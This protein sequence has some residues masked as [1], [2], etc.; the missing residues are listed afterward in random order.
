VSECIEG[1]KIFT[2]HPSINKSRRRR[3]EK[4][5]GRTGWKGDSNEVF[6]GILKSS[7]KMTRF[8]P[9]KGPS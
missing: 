8:F 4:G 2:I 3:S 6:F 1:R 7:M 9:P 5:R